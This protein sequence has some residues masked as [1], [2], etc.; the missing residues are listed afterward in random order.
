MPGRCPQ[1]YGSPW[2][3]RARDHV[4]VG[5]SLALLQCSGFARCTSCSYYCLMFLKVPVN[6]TPYMLMLERGKARQAFQI[7]MSPFHLGRV[8][9]LGFFFV[10]LVFV[11]FCFSW[12]MSLCVTLRQ[13][14]T[15][16][17]APWG[18]H[19]QEL[20]GGKW[21]SPAQCSPPQRG[22]KPPER[23]EAKC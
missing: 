4:A 13:G 3:T 8:G 22:S 5:H 23:A 14:W 20:W 10:W 21:S 17:Q 15:S 2:E 9:F 18:L 12:G 16:L 7:F 1:Q 19:C 11:L 6:F